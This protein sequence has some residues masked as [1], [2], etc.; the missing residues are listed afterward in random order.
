M[1]VQQETSPLQRS[2]PNKGAPVS[3]SW[4]HRKKKMGRNFGIPRVILN[5]KWAISII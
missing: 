1:E 5:Y 2:Q 4:K 3:H